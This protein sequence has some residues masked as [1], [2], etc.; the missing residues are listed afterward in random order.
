[1]LRK[2]YIFRLSCWV[3][4]LLA[5]AFLLAGCNMWGSPE[6][7]VGQSEQQV[8]SSWGQPTAR[9]SLPEGGVRLQYS[10]QP[11]GRYAWMIDL[12]QAGQ[13]TQV[14]QALQNKYFMQIPVDGSWGR[15]DVLREFGPPALVDHVASWKGDIWNYR[16]W[17][18]KYM[19]YYIYFD[20]NGRVRRAEAGIDF[21][22]DRDTWRR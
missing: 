14:Y 1:M 8:L 3:F 10:G 7:W 22:M 13:V 5:A 16:W 9:V 21:S 11:W 20:E 18:I 6:K 12:D 17:D 2:S 4:S 15:E 19:F